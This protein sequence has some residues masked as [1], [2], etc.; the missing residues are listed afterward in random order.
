MTEIETSNFYSPSKFINFLND[1]YV[2][3]KFIRAVC[4]FEGDDSFKNRFNKTCVKPL[5]ITLESENKK[6]NIYLN[7]DKINKLFGDSIIL[8]F[9]Y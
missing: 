1:K 6:N 8:T 2:N 4:Y 3:N 5:F 9:P 7:Y